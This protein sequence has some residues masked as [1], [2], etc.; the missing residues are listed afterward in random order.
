MNRMAKVFI[1]HSKYDKLGIVEP[2]TAALESEGH[3]CWVD[4][5]DV[6]FG[7]SIPAAI[8]EGIQQSNAFVVVLSRAY[9][10]SNWC[11]RELNAIEYHVISQRK[12]I[13]FIRVDDAP[14][15]P[16]LFADHNHITFS[17]REAPM[18]LA[19]KITRALSATFVPRQAATGDDDYVKM[20]FDAERRGAFGAN[21]LSRATRPADES[22]TPENEGIILIKPGGTYLRSL[23]ERIVP[24]DTNQVPDQAIAT[25]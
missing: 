4:K 21:L 24:T 12:P 22:L 13:L 2:V 11:K 9:A 1:S 23:F 18:D 17:R 14:P 7:A 5:T 19:A 8:S 3:K 20:L 15:V 16:V 25:L 10:D 6:P